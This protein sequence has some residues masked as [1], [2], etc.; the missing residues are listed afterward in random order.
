MN[1]IEWLSISALWLLLGLIPVL[2]VYIL[3]MPRLRVKIPSAVHFERLGFEKKGLQQKRTLIA[4]A[5][6]LIILALLAIGASQPLLT[7]GR[8]QKRHV[9]LIMDTS[10]SMRSC[11]KPGGKSRFDRAKQLAGKLVM[12]ME[13]GDQMLIM[14]VGAQAGVVQ[15]FEKERQTLQQA[16]EGMEAGYECTRLMEAFKLTAEI[17]EPLKDVQVYLISDGAAVLKAGRGEDQEKLEKVFKVTRFVGVGDQAENMGIVGFGARRNRDSDRDF[18]VLLNIFSMFKERRHARLELKVGADVIDVEELELEPGRIMSKE[19]EKEVILGGPFQAEIT[20]LGEDG[21][22]TADALLEDNKAYEWLPKLE[23]ITV[24]LVSAPKKTNMVVARQEAETDTG[25]DVKADTDK[26]A[27]DKKPDYLEAFMSSSIGVKGFMVPPGKYHPDFKVDAMIFYNWYPAPDQLPE[28]DTV[29]INT[30][31]ETPGKLGEY[32]ER[33]MMQNWN[34]THPLMNYIALNNLVLSEMRPWEGKKKELETVAQAVQGPLI[35]AGKRQ[36]YK[37]I[38][39]AFDPRGSDLPFRVA[40]PVFLSNALQWFQQDRQ[41]H[42]LSQISPGQIYKI[43]VREDKEKIQAIRVINPQ[44]ESEDIPVS[45]GYALYSNTHVP[46][47]Y[48]YRIGDREH[49]F[50]VSLCDQDETMIAEREV[51]REKFEAAKQEHAPWVARELWYLIGLMVL[52]AVGVESY[53]FHQRIIF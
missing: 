51:W 5:I 23:R 18:S 17:I 15:Q 46:G 34:R 32:I 2:L 16:V 29:F 30:S 24:L 21:N 4:C 52:V 8:E 47:I 22:E 38:Y 31:G 50:A 49:G 37:T 14:Q 43:R 1:H 20:I 26:E 11:D 28:C 3:R 53:L 25:A 10:A 48:Q 40:F 12:N 7:S 41:D 6:Q 39:M 13:H 42:S 36:Q 19:F 27:K 44:G 9:V 35:L 45:G 33:P